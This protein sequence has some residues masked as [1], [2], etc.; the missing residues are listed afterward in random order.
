M[1]WKCKQYKRSVQTAAINPCVALM[2][3]GS[4]SSNFNPDCLKILI[5]IIRLVCGNIP[6]FVL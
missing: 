4:F 6:L 3:P 1:I 2:T 5:E